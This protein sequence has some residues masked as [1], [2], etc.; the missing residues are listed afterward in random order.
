MKVDEEKLRKLAQTMYDY[1]IAC[2][3]D[4]EFALKKARETIAFI[5]WSSLNPEKKPAE[6]WD[7][8]AGTITSSPGSC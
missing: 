7:D 5:R 8:Y 1:H 2:E 6:F 4:H 3:K